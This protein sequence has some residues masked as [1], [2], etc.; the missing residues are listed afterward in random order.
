MDPVMDGI[1]EAFAVKSRRS[2]EVLIITVSGELDAASVELLD[3]AIREA[4]KG[5]SKTILV[6]LRELSF[7]DSVGLSLLCGAR[8]RC[9]RIRFVPSGHDQVARLVAL[10][11]TDEVLGYPLTG[12]PA[13]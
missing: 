2:D 5:D 1:P 13:D 4:E 10:S 11:G 12:G 8:G 6:D 7:M 9:D 3:G